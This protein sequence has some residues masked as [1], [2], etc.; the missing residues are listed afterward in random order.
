M[1]NKSDGIFTNDYK[2]TTLD[3]HRIEG[4]ISP[5]IQK[6]KTWGTTYGNSI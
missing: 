2:V 4:I 5:S 6:S 1:E 3:N